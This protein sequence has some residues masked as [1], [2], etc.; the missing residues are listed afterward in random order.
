MGNSARL[1]DAF[2]IRMST[3][4]PVTRVTSPATGKYLTITL[5]NESYGIS[6]MKVREII[7]MQKI[8]PVPGMP[9]HV[10]GVLN[11]RP[12]FI[13]LPSLFHPNHS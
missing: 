1:N 8:T 4:S 2:P 6:V 11:L 5:D 3:H 7:R 13:S 12:F 10:K 9:E